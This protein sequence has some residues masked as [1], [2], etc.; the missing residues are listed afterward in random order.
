MKVFT[1]NNAG[2]SL[3][4][5]LSRFRNSSF[6]QEVLEK[7]DTQQ[8]QAGKPKVPTLAQKLYEPVKKRTGNDD[9][10]KILDCFL[11]KAQ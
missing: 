10:E 7:G 6:I 2:N 9:K 5:S 1:L 3:K 4:R 8:R 11:I